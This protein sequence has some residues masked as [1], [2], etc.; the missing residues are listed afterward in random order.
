MCITIMDGER[1]GSGDERF[2]G[3]AHVY[4]SLASHALSTKNNL[5]TA[6]FITFPD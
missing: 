4:V 5:I 1:Y 6:T 2:E 3:Y